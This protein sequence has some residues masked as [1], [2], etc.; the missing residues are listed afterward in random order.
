MSRSRVNEDRVMEAGAGK[1]QVLGL[2][3]LLAVLRS[4]ACILNE[5]AIHCRIPSREVI[6]S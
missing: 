2:V 4:L 6:Q 3:G 1:A 5:M